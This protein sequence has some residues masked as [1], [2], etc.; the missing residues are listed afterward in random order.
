MTTKQI[1]VYRDSFILLCSLKMCVLF[2][3]F[4]FNTTSVLLSGVYFQGTTIGMA[5]IMSMCTVEQSGGIVMVSIKPVTAPTKPPPSSS[6]LWIYY[7]QAMHC[8]YSTMIY[9]EKVFSNL[10]AGHL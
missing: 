10:L 3:I 9:T 4:F 5:P 7:I 2:N 8:S 6:S 1:I